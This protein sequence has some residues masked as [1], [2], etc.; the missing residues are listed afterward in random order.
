MQGGCQPNVKNATRAHMVGSA[1]GD[2]QANQR[3]VSDVL[4][5]VLLSHPD[6]AK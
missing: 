2:A 6:Q 1:P 4:P 5:A 3:S